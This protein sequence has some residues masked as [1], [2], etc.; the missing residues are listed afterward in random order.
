MLQSVSPWHVMV[1]VNMQNTR[2]GLLE[3]RMRGIA[4]GSTSTINL[5]VILWT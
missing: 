2:L 4:N 1:L 5:I 3:R